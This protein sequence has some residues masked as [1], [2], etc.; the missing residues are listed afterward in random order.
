M[1]KYRNPIKN[2]ETKNVAGNVMQELKEADLVN[3]SAGEGA[4]KVSGGNFC[5]V[6]AE[7]SLNSLIV[8]C[9]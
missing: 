5:T 8:A 6:T 9:C 2:I 7:C 3:F 4:P 1:S